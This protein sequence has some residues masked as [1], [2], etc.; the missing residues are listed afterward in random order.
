MKKAILGLSIIVLSSLALAGC[1]NQAAP[2]ASS[3]SIISSSTSSRLKEKEVEFYSSADQHAPI[4]LFFDSTMPDIPFISLKLAKEFLIAGAIGTSD[5]VYALTLLDQEGLIT[6]SR[7]NGSKVMID[8]PHQKI[9][10][11]CFEKFSAA[12]FA[13]TPLDPVSLALHDGDGKDLYLSR[14]ADSS[15]SKAQGTPLVVDL[16]H[17]DIPLI[18]EGGEGYLPIP[19]FSDLFASQV[20]G[21]LAYNGTA[22]FLASGSFNPIRTPYYASP[23]RKRSESLAQ[24]TYHEL[25]L[26]LDVY[27]GLKSGHGISD[28]DSYLENNGLKSDLLSTDG[29]VAD[30]ALAKLMN[31]H[32]EDFHSGFLADSSYAGEKA[33]SHPTSS[34]DYVIEASNFR[35]KSV[36]ALSLGDNPL[37][38]QE[39]NDTAF[40]TFDGFTALSGDY[41]TNPV[42][43]ELKV[44]NADSGAE[45]TFAIVE[46]SHRMITRE[47]SPIKN[48]VIDLSCNG[49][50]ALD[51]LAYIAGWLQTY[52]V[53]DV[54][55][56]IDGMH[57]ENYYKVDVNLDR[58]FDTNDCIASKRL[59]CLISP[60]SFSCGNYLP[61]MLKIRQKA[62]M[63]GQTSGGGG[64]MVKPLSTADGALFQISGNMLMGVAK[65]GS[66]LDIDQGVDPDYRLNDAS[67][68]YDRTTLAANIDNGVYGSV[69]Q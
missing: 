42:T 35:F 59:Y 14:L 63:I 39:I 65:N 9:T 43:K 22:L 17:Y 12:S 27:Y 60:N 4:G 44:Y 34:P 20:Y 32:F 69:A 6:L 67:A 48:V 30:L 21:T 62:T 7:E 36:R 25:C 49:G 52:D 53:L 61:A 26:S 38:Y 29:A 18:Y 68:F 58:V 19:T 11:S 47:N 41:Y 33:T 5:S 57:C 40:V 28:F 2:S 24:F 8:F 15:V 37:A 13:A 1:G 50:G 46:Y 16:S 10:F 66:F 51:S 31:S 64:C 45:D 55:S 23:A 54:K 3:I 56:A